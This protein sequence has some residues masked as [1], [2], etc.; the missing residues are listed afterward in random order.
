MDLYLFDGRKNSDRHISHSVI[1]L[2]EY[3]RR[4]YIKYLMFYA[5][6]FLK[7]IFNEFFLELFRTRCPLQLKTTAFVRNCNHML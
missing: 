1:L 2:T 4:N 5:F 6:I 3:P 7:R